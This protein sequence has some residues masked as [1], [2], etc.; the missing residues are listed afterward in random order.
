ML[1]MYLSLFI[2]LLL[3]FPYTIQC[4]SKETTTDDA[5]IPLCRALPKSE[6][7]TLY[8]QYQ[9]QYI[10]MDLVP[11]IVDL[12]NHEIK[13]SIAEGHYSTRIQYRIDTRTDIVRYAEEMLAVERGPL[14]N[15]YNNNAEYEKFIALLPIYRFKNDNEHRYTLQYIKQ[16]YAEIQIGTPEPQRDGMEQTGGNGRHSVTVDWSRI[17]N[18]I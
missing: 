3:L 5:S 11:S 4:Q 6:I 16:L 2:V 10:R 13:V 14:K 17:L 8:Q 12:I 18:R 7:I 9:Q 15:L 1:T